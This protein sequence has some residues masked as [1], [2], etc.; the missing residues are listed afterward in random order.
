M[1][2][3]INTAAEYSRVSIRHMTC[4]VSN[5]QAGTAVGNVSSGSPDLRFPRGELVP[6]FCPYFLE[7]RT[8]CKTS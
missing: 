1:E 8:F 2:E 7:I 4:T 6:P 3:T 5:E